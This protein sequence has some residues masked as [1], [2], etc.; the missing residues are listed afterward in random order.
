M[1]SPQRA[2]SEKLRVGLVCYGLDR[3][4]SGTTRVAQQLGRALLRTDACDVTFL[5]PYQRGPF[6]SATTQSWYLPGCR[7]LPGL[8]A[9]G[10]PIIAWAARQLDLDVVHDPVGVSPFTL[11]RWAGRFGRVLTVHD[12]IA[13]RYPEGYPWLN[14]VLHR[15]FVP[16]TLRNVD[17]V[18]TDSEH[19]LS[20]VTGLVSGAAARAFTVPLGVDERFRP[21]PEDEARAVAARYGLQP[22]YVLSVGAQ[23]ARKNVAALVDAMAHV[24]KEFPRHRLAIAGPTQWK[25]SGVDEAIARLA[26]PELVVRLGYVKDDDLPALYS[27]AD[28][29][30]FPSL[31][32]GFGLPVLEAMACGTP[33]VCSDTGALAET[34]GGAALLAHPLESGAIAVAISQA[35]GDASLRASLRDSGLERARQFTWARTAALTAEVYRKVARA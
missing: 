16:A 35:L 15:Y 25:Y 22:P 12:A 8:I 19:S 6:R 26:Y 1:T 31:Y 20:E 3:P 23:Q 5:T 4:L 11:G 21:V 10:G 9:L 14:N 32:E 2:V 28:V 17:A 24:H 7:L 27:L 13:F 29:F 18:V 30:A 34:A 33:V